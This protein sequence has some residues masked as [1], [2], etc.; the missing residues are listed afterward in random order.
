MAAAAAAAPILA[1][2]WYRTTPLPD[3]SP[4]SKKRPAACLTELS[5]RLAAAFDAGLHCDVTLQLGPEASTLSAHRVVLRR[6]PH[7]GLAGPSAPEQVAVPAGIRAEALLAVLRAHYLELEGGAA[8]ELESD[9]TGIGP[10]AQLAAA[11]AQCDEEERSLLETI[12]GPPDA[13]QWLSLRES[14]NTQWFADCT[15]QVSSCGISIPAHRVLIAGVNDGHYF[16]AA[17]R[18]PGASAVVTMPEGLSPE[19]LQALLRMR[20]GADEVDVILILE[21]RHFADLFDWPAVRS[22]CEERLEA[23]LVDTNAMDTESLLTVVAHV[24]QSSAI[25]ARLQAAALSSAVRQWSKMAELAQGTMSQSRRDEL[26]VLHRIRNR[27]GHVCGSLE[28]YLHA[29]AD[30]LTDWERRLALTAPATVKRNIG[31][32]WEHWHQLLFEYGRINGAAVA[33]RWREKVRE[34]REQLRR[35]RADGNAARLHLPADR[36]WFEASDEWREVPQNAVCPGGLEYRFDMETGRN[37]AR[38]CA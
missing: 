10:C 21:M 23:L 11:Y 14:V 18:W 22:R 3:S 4:A 2:E 35:E 15:L 38:L 27:D 37:Y 1:I 30:D 34:R 12:F 7:V 32:A 8:T 9:P 19:A 28:E 24:D 16:A 31:K 29:C 26:G 6:N 20:Y 13:R 5:T 33:E 17:L 25:P 36:V